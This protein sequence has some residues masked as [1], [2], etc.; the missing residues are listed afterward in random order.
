MPQ[1]PKILTRKSMCPSRLFKVEA[2]ELEFSNGVRR[3]YEYLLSGE[4]AAVI[5]VPMITDTEVLLV[6]EYGI[7]IESYE[8]G[9]PKGKVDP[10]ETL[11]EAAN[12]ELKEEAGFG[13]HELVLLKCMSQSPNY[14][15]HKTHIVLARD[16]Y[17][18]RLVGDEPEQMAVERWSLNDMS[19][20]MERNDL[21]EARTIA[22]LY[23]TRDWLAKRNIL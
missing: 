4:S 21:T 13:A 20:L 2:A 1:L 7:G 19:T 23:L 11:Q 6:Q 12:R 3:E 17:E 15:Q 18:E 16:L 10:G 22:A 14:M 9:L 5:I 8:W